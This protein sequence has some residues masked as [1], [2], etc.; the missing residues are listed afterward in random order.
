MAG[1]GQGTGTGYI[2]KYTQDDRLLSSLYIPLSKLAT[3][4]FSFNMQGGIL[5]AYG[6]SGSSTEVP[7]PHPTPT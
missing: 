3:T 7:H 6:S 4:V 1:E 2:A 5:Q